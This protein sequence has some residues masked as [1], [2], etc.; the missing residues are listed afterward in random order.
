MQ[1]EPATIHPGDSITVVSADK[2]N[3]KVPGSGWTVVAGHVGNG[4]A[5]VQVKSSDK[6]DGS[7]RVE[8]TLP[9]D[10]PIGEA[11]AGVDNW[12]YSTCP[13][14][15]SCASPMSSFTVKP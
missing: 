12:D 6:F 3:V 9:A 4:K 2:C 14:A 11:Y 15:G 13:D 5:L 7:F 1:I 10:F 8:L